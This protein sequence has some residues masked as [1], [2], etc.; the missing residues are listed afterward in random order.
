MRSLTHVN[1]LSIGAA[2]WLAACSS[3]GLGV[4]RVNPIESQ[5]VAEIAL[6]RGD[7]R[8][9]VQ[10][11]LKV[12]QQVKD[13]EYARRATELATEYGYD[14]YALAAAERWVRLA[15]DDAEAHAYLGRLLT[16][17]GQLDRAWTSLEL[18]LGPSA[19]RLD[20]DYALLANDLATSGA[21]RQ[22]LALFE[23]FNAT[24][25][26]NPGITRSL[27]ELAA[28]AGDFD[29]AVTAVRQTVALRP[30]W[31]DT[32]MW[33]ARLLLATGEKESAFEQMAFAV[34]MNPG[35]ER[36]LEFVRLLAAAGELQS[37]QERLE[38]LTARFPGEA[39]IPLVQA[40]LYEQAGE[41]EAA[42]AIYLALLARGI[43]RNES[44]WNLGIIAFS[45]SDYEGAIGLFGQVSSGERLEAA[46]VASSQAYLQLENPDAAL[47]VLRDFAEFYPQRAAAMQQ[48]QAQ[49]LAAAGR[50][51][52]AL[53]ATDAALEYQPWNTA[54]WLFRGGLF[55]ET[56]RMDAAV[57]AFKTACKL[58]PDDPTTLNAYGYT[59]TI[60]TRKY[61]EARRYIE[62]A[63]ALEP[64]N[65]AIM[66]SMGWVLFKQG[67]PKEA[68]PWLQRA[69]DSL[70]DPEVAA[71]LGEVLWELGRRAEAE[72]V[73]T[74]AAAEFPDNAVLAEVR[75]RLGN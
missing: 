55:E 62:Q 31:D 52:E 23:R 58:A 34:E 12:A 49:I 1:L 68:L 5:L 41:T 60:A 28:Q 64:E 7:Y 30:D 75:E 69:H 11:Y 70:P 8:A 67:K 71:H 26:D 36:E 40:G 61:A 15:P 51:D 32:R 46:T 21:A 37:A 13:P 65:P 59:L 74:A 39:S 6:E 73:W 42:E 63:L 56:G 66:D 35:L 17:R 19:E 53:A 4:A 50:F 72:A 48:P 47:Q 14:G 38:R 44:L 24:Y 20:Q 25:P 29:R 22:G 45:R 16:Q 33:L 54:V 57:D 9:A 10:E 43:Y 3:S 2:L 18:A 27:G